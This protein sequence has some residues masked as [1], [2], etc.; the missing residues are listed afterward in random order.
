MDFDSIL[1]E[2]EKERQ[3]AFEIKKKESSNK[4]KHENEHDDNEENREDTEHDETEDRE[5]E[6]EEE[7]KETEH[8][9]IEEKD[10]DKESQHEEKE[11]EEDEHENNEEEKE[12]NDE[13]EGREESEEKAEA[14]E[15]H[16][17]TENR[18]EEHETT[19]EKT[20]EVEEIEKEE[21]EEPKEP[22]HKEEHEGLKEKKTESKE[23]SI[24]KK[25]PKQA[26]KLQ[27]TKS[28]IKQNKFSTKQ[29]DVIKMPKKTK[30]PQNL[31]IIKTTKIKK[32]IKQPT[33]SDKFVKKI[34]INAASPVEIKRLAK[35]VARLKEGLDKLLK[36]QKEN[37]ALIL[38]RQKE[39]ETGA[40]RKNREKEIE[41]IRRYKEKEA[42]ALRRHTELK[43]ELNKSAKKEDLSKESQIL[44]NEV[45]KVRK[46]I[47]YL[48]EFQPEI[49]FNSIQKLNEN[50]TEMN[51]LFR[52][53]AELMQ[54]P[55]PVQSKLK[56]LFDENE[57]IAQG[58]LAV[59][60]AV[61]E[62]KQVGT[63]Q[64]EDIKRIENE[65]RLPLRNIAS[66]AQTEDMEAPSIPAPP[67]EFRES[68]DSGESPEPFGSF[69]KDEISRETGEINRNGARSGAPIAQSDEEIPMP[70]EMTPI[71]T[72]TGAPIS[73]Q[74]FGS[75]TQSSAIR[76]AQPG[77]FGSARVSSSG[78]G[79]AFPNELPPSP[80]QFT[81][82]QLDQLASMVPPLQRSGSGMSQF[83]PQRMQQP[84]QTQQTQFQARQQSSQQRPARFSRKKEELKV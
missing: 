40:I 58:I 34:K 56:K 54:K 64:V 29:K 67:P 79:S 71:P 20:E 21:I 77:Q 57:K 45:D 42:G 9:D 19:E 8:E 49:L 69:E 50:I 80:T 61:N 37:D 74:S 44:A 14:E 63:A 13:S 3:K 41:T 30:L 75:Q 55:D 1:R 81:P 25:K 6:H 62:M 82:E 15:E 24:E 28:I 38:K 33:T 78:I 84:F 66:R 65:I 47:A 7:T 83:P 27:S 22:E 48:K 31:K 60:D 35:D 26:V 2:M 12:G 76:P 18:E 52:L 32:I 11:Q 4:K 68:I 17:E 59:L 70:P 10:E 39:I 72:A 43:N 46:D 36:T 16:N 53:A 5:E 51:S 23:K 73:S